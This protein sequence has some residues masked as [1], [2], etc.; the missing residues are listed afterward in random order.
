MLKEKRAD[1]CGWSSEREETEVSSRGLTCA[2]HKPA[3]LSLVGSCQW[4]L[5]S[6]V[7]R[8]QLLLL[9]P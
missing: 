1:Q 3:H 7:T 2:P 9:S 5:H 4:C 8:L 6:P